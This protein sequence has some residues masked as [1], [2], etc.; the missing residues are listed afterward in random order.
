[1]PFNINK[2]L[3]STTTAPLDTLIEPPAAQDYDAVFDQITE[4]NFRTLPGQNGE[5]D[6]LIVSLPL[7]LRG[8][9]AEA[10]EERLGR[11]PLTVRKDVWLDMTPEGDLDFGPNKNVD[12]G[13]VREAVGQNQEGV[14]WNLTRLNG[15]GPVRITLTHRLDK[16]DPT[17]RYP[18]VG[19]IVAK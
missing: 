19:K 3:E 12:L 16:D 1:M 8:P 18:Q 7:E 2:I 6:R 15:A 17:I 14:S 9:E 11:K 5:P 13:R 4:K 10:E